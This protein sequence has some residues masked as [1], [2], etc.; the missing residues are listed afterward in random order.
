MV[1]SVIIPAL[2]EA[3]NLAR[4]L[5]QVRSQLDATDEL[6]VVDNGSSDKTAEVASRCGAEVVFEPVRGRSQARN[7][8]IKRSRGEIV[9]FLDADCTPQ[10]GWLEE[11]TQPF[12]DPQ[13]GCVA[14]AI[15]NIDAGTPFSAYLV[16]KGHLAQSVYFEHPFYPYAA[17][18]NA[19]F[20]RV[21]LDRIGCFDELLWA[22][23]DADLS[24]RMQLETSFKI[25]ATPRA[26]VSHRQDLS[27]RGF[28]KQKRRHAQGSVLLYKKY[29]KYREGEIASFK[30]T[31]WE[32][33]S[34][35]KRAFD[36]L[37][38]LLAVRLGLRTSPSRDQGYQ[39]VIELGEK[40][41]RIEGSIRNHV[42][43]P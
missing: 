10:R 40:L 14:G 17:T 39:L 24:W 35:C 1:K 25:V 18:G 3:E 15:R 33:H 42:W 8:G 7:A 16:K 37:V 12:S 27:F 21:V 19:A 22:G 11:L 38:E 6:I 13:I 31:Y 28:L 20:R 9:V 2:N 29:R 23:H 36:C 34:I 26:L 41:G 32:Y 30:E 43:Y 4:N 5:P